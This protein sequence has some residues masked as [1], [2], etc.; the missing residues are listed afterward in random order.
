VFLFPR[1]SPPIGSGFTRG[2]PTIGAFARSSPI[3]GTF[4][5]HEYGQAR[6]FNNNLLAK[7]NKNNNNTHKTARRNF[8]MS[9]LQ[10]I[11]NILISS[12]PQIQVK[13]ILRTPR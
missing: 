13:K 5:D 12:L 6:S 3:G 4:V 7:N 11:R 9:S 1:G 8:T 10:E 2:S